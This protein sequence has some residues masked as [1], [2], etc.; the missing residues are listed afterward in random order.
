MS[1]L[2]RSIIV[3]SALDEIDCKIKRIS[4]NANAEEA[5]KQLDKLDDFVKL[6]DS[7]KY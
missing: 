7:R 1:K 5:V 6:G 4:K 2:N 3:I